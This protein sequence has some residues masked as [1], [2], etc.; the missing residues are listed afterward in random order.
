MGVRYRVL[1]RLD[2]VQV[3]PFL[4]CH[5]RQ[6]QI[7]VGF[8][9]RVR[10]HAVVNGAE[11]QMEV[12]PADRRHVNVDAEAWVEDQC[13]LDWPAGATLVAQRS[14]QYPGI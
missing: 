2:D 11:L 3:G 1:E 4:V 13:V 7:V 10:G 14:P 9:V 12:D 6:G 5:R 8:G